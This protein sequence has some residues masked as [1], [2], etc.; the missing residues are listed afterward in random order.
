MTNTF[1]EVRILSKTSGHARTPPQGTT[2]LI[3]TEVIS[4]VCL[5]YAVDPE[6]L[7]QLTRTVNVRTVKNVVCYLAVRLLGHHG[8]IVGKHLGFGRSG[9]S[10]AAGRPY[11]LLKN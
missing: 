7:C 9:V 11:G 1:L 2:V 6:L 8:V 5:H 4:R 10:V 3:I